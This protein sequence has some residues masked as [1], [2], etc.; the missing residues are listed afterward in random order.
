MTSLTFFDTL[1]NEA[2]IRFV[3][4]VLKEF[5]HMIYDPIRMSCGMNKERRVDWTAFACLAALCVVSVFLFLKE[6]RIDLVDFSVHM[7]IAGDFDFSD[8]HTI[9]SRL[10][11]PMWHLLVSII[12][13][14]GVPL[15]WAAIFVSVLCKAV[16]YALVYWL[17]DTLSMRQAKRWAVAL[18]SL[19][20]VTVT[21]LWIRPVSWCVYKGVGS[22]NVWHNPTQLAV[23]AAMLMVMPWLVH[24]W[25][26][27]ERALSDGRRNV[28]LP[29]WKV[30]VLIILTMG[31]LA[32][33]PT[34]MQALLPAAFVMYLVEL[35]RHK[36]EWR[37]FGQIV[38]AFLPAVAYFLLQY[39]YYTGVVVEFTSGV[40]I[41]ITAQ[42]AW[43]AVRNTLM[44]SACPFMALVACWRKGML[45]D[46]SLLLALL[47]TAFSVLEAMAFRETGL[48]EGHGNFTWAANSSSMYLWVVM[49]GV[50]LRS[51]LSDRKNGMTALRKI[52]YALTAAL[53]AWHV[54][55]GVYYIWH[56]L[57]HAN[58]F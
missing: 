23:S 28:M 17:V 53:F 1:L 55:S 46:R 18:L 36:S 52:G 47:M 35:I 54:V 45:K 50:F 7:N 38:V 48:R 5:V 33:K 15:H 26:E 9:T 41:G 40:E 8:L 49:L 2:D 29:W 12:Y 11:Y 25:C 30:V 13:Q 44:M 4:A 27:F 51:F 14:L 20:A 6:A 24:C 34:F 10:A 22:P 56:L 32:C 31:S 42:S 21:G 58:A 3:F 19:A 39:L 37:Y 57:V 43:L 16:A